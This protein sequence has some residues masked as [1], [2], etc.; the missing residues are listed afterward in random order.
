MRSL[1]DKD[2]I[3]DTRGW[4]IAV[5]LIKIKKLWELKNW[6]TSFGL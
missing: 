5:Y 6:P 2:G 3:H 4:K 1:I